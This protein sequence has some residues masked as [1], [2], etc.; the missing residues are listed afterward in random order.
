M[1]MIGRDEQYSLFRRLK[2]CK[3][4]RKLRNHIATQLT[5]PIPNLKGGK[6]KRVCKKGYICLLL[7]YNLG[8][9]CLFPIITREKINKQAKRCLHLGML[10][11]K[12]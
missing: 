10:L 4:K 12:T 11:N 6:R 9:R 8:N 3:I 5:I 1:T 7:S 2:V